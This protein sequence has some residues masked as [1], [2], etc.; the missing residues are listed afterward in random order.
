MANNINI[1]SFFSGA[2]FLDLG[3][4]LCAPYKVVY[5]NEFHKPFN[6]VYRYSRS[7][8]GIS[9]PVYGHH[10]GDITKLLETANLN[11]LKSLLSDSKSKALTGMIGGPPCPDFSVA[12]KNR[13]REGDNGKLSGTY[14]EIICKTKPDFFLFENVKGLYKTAR[15][16]EFFEELKG[17]F[18]KAGYSLTEQLTNSLE[19]GVPQD[20]DRILL[21]GFHKDAISRLSLKSKRH[22][23]LDFPWNK[24]KSFQLN[25]IK[26]LPWPTTSPYREN[27]PTTI[28]E[29]LPIEL[30][31]QYWW[32]KNDVVNHPNAN[33]FFQPRAGI[34]RFSTK[35]EGDD[36]KKCYKRLHRWRYS[37]TA[38]Y[39]NNEVHIHPYLPRR[40]SVAE[41]L[42]IQ[43]LP[44]EFELPTSMTLTDSFK[45]IGNGVPYLLADGVAKTILSYIKHDYNNENI[46]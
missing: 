29:G 18:R 11:A 22:E 2:G 43:S 17:K 16:R 5:V 8:M 4:E 15:H 26:Q 45:T 39:G 34:V 38:A 10:V 23:L 28:P 7:K 37:P 1:F 9:E 20:R 30:T 6:D 19:Y 42:A 13:G 46:N 35:D 32:E 24:Y 36:T 25:D 27:V 40:I 33:M 41:A 21:V 44:K 31:V 3:F 14:C 12:G